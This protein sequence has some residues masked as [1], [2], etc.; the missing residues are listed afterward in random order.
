MILGEFEIYME[1][2]S[3][4]N[5]AQKQY[6]EKPMTMVGNKTPEWNANA[7]LNGDNKALSH[8]DFAGKWH[9]I[10]SYPF[11]FSGLCPTE[12]QGLENLLDDF[13]AEGVEV[14]GASADSFLVHKKWFEDGETF[15]SPITHPI[16]ADTSHAFC[17]AFDILREDLGVA[18]RAMVLIDPEGTIRMHSVND[19]AVSRSPEEM[20]RM[21]QAFVSGGPCPANWK[22]G[23]EFAG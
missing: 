14:I 23:E 18:Y 4:A 16:I 8:A 10:Y 20:L 12:I 1:I 11:N 3:G 7:Y 21:T 15:S 13:E 9:M 17:K 19:L 6:L 5:L 22:K 2:N